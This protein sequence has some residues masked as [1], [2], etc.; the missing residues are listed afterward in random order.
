MEESTL[1]VQ[2][3]TRVRGGEGWMDGPCILVAI[4][5]AVAIKKHHFQENTHQELNI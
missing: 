3:G 2:G 5:V 1:G 4:I